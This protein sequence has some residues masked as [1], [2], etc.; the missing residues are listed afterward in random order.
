MF[1]V[2]LIEYY[3]PLPFVPFI[4]TVGSPLLFLSHIP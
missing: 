2:Q 4:D 1:L 3:V